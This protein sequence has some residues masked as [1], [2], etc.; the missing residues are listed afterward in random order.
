MKGILKMMS[1]SSKIPAE[2]Y[3][4]VNLKGQA[5]D[6]ESFKV[7]HEYKDDGS[8]CSKHK[9]KALAI[10][11]KNG[12]WV[13]YCHRCGSRGALKAMPMSA[14]EIKEYLSNQNQVKSPTTGGVCIPSDTVRLFKDDL[15]PHTRK[16]PWDAIT[17]LSM[18]KVDNYMNKYYFGWSI[19]QKRIIM[20][21]WSSEY[22]GSWLKRDTLM[23]WAG[24]DP[25][26][27]IKEERVKMNMPKYIT[28]KGAGKDRV[29]FTAAGP[30]A[31]SEGY[32]I[33]VEDIISA[34]RVSEAMKCYAFALLNADLPRDL[35]DSIGNKS[36]IILWLDSNMVNNMIQTSATYR[37]LGFDID[38]VSTQ[39]DPKKY[40]DEGI[41]T[42]IAN[43]AR[44]IT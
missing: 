7:V 32:K 33:I 2:V 17:W 14:E 8:I 20:P 25:T 38:W 43:R 28:R 9:S 39:Q 4:I 35:M 41:R 16:A 34:I 40:S 15:S 36:K 11:K 42:V 13:W 19:E 3:D 5:P 31:N 1:L 27:R 6:G 29:I 26:D 10:T 21:I 12:G 18:Y 37:Q 30:G 22:V 24:R 44:I 23:G